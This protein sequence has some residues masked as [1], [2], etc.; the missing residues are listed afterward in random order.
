MIIDKPPT[1][2]YLVK[3]YTIKYVMQLCHMHQKF[4]CGSA[5][6]LYLYS[7]QSLQFV[8]KFKF[9][10]LP[11]PIFP[12]PT[13]LQ[14]LAL[15]GCDSKEVADHVRR[16]F[17]VLGRAAVGLGFVAVRGQVVGRGEV[18]AAAARR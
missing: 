15:R 5:Y 12:L 3:V 10:H 9:C 16:L 1:A 6:S 11:G 13:C 18:V 8:I 17:N 14:I 4:E 7:L 2:A